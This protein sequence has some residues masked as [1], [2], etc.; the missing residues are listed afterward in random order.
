MPPPALA[1]EADAALRRFRQFYAELF[2]IKRLLREGDWSS[3]LGHR[4]AAGT[5][6]QQILLAVRLRLR[7]AIVAPGFGAQAS[8][9][10]G[11][12]F[13]TQRLGFAEQGLGFAGASPGAPA[14]VDHGYVWA[15]VTDAALLHDVSWPGREGWAETP[16]EVVLYRTR[17]AGDR[18]FE[19]AEA[20][21]RRRTPDPDG[22]AM[23]ILLAFEVGF[24]G[25][26]RGT[27]DHGEIE[28]LKV[29]LF[30][31]VFH[32]S[33][34]LSD[35]FD[36]LTVGAAEPLSIGSP[37]RLAQVRPWGM[38]VA[39][40]VVFYLLASLSIWWNQVGDI[41]DRATDAARSLGQLG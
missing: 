19:A 6:E 4:A 18:I 41:A 24:R 27:D 16:L 26:Y 1:P 7:S 35:D 39:G 3:L 2:A 12:G 32:G 33:R 8:G 23:T 11:L 15:A 22:L 40:V 10:Q 21:I 25:R 30:D 14:G 17:I 34:I 31:L 13:A 20:L 9:A 29:R 38:A 37:V 28:R 36:E 5:L